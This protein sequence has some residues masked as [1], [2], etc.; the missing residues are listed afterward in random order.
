MCKQPQKPETGGSGSTAPPTESGTFPEDSREGF[1]SAA[2]LPEGLQEALARV[3]ERGGVLFLCVFVLLLV[4]NS[5]TLTNPPYWDEIVGTHN[6]ALWFRNHNFHFFGLYAEE[7]TYFQ[8][9]SAVHFSCLTA[10]VLAVLYSFLPP[11]GVFVV[12]HLL[13]IVCG[14]V[15]IVCFYRIM[16][17]YVSPVVAAAWCLAAAF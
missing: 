7:E 13:S 14:T 5:H 17:R 12:A 15:V 2:P 10:L 9:G 6:Q 3:T 11:T 1:D 8:G 4:Y 16:S